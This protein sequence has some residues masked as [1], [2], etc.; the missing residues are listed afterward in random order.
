MVLGLTWSNFPSKLGIDESLLS[1]DVSYL[2][3]SSLRI[4]SSLLPLPHYGKLSKRSR[5]HASKLLAGIGKRP[6]VYGLGHSASCIFAQSSSSLG[7]EVLI[8]ARTQHVSRGAFSI[9][10][11]SIAYRDNSAID[12]YADVNVRDETR[13]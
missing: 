10:Y 13:E 12:L 9:S 8:S 4:T 7:Y 11:S 5:H 3:L 2:M 6:K 1:I